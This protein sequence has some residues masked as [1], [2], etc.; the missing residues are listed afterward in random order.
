NAS[1]NGE[2]SEGRKRLIFSLIPLTSFVKEIPSIE[3][4]SFDPLSGKYVIRKSN[5]IPIT[6]LPAARQLQK[7]E[8]VLAPPLAGNVALQETKS[9]TFHM[10]YILLFYA[11]LFLVALMGV[12]FLIKGIV[13]GGKEKNG[14]S[15]QVMLEAIKTKNAPQA[16]CK[17]I[18]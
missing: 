13:Q 2:E 18:K 14:T 16:C 9:E 12:A 8:T 5:P 1:A 11:L 4:S 6:V 7:Q 17:K 15:R 10:D 3:F